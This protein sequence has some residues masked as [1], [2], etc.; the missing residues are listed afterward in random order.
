MHQD[1]QRRPHRFALRCGKMFQHRQG[2]EDPGFA[3]LARHLFAPGGELQAA[4]AAIV[5]FRH[6]LHQPRPLQAVGDLRQG[7]ERNAQLAAQ[8]RHRP[9]TFA[10]DSAQ[11]QLRQGQVIGRVLLRGSQSPSQAGYQPGDGLGSF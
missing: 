1:F 6:A 4:D 10:Q 11:P 2:A 3:A 8:G 5:F 7:A 9:R